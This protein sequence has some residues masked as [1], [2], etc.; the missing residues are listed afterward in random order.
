M[1]TR[2][3]LASVSIYLTTPRVTKRTQLRDS[4]ARRGYL[5]SA[6]REAFLQREAEK[7]E[8]REAER[9]GVC[10]RKGAARERQGKDRRKV[11]CAEAGYDWSDLIIL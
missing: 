6:I 2:A 5:G 8:E 10:Q 11:S 3:G 7:L 9:K 4:L 1:M